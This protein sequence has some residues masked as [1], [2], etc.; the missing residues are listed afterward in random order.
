MLKKVTGRAA[1]KEIF[2][3]TAEEEPTVQGITTAEGLG[4]M[5]FGGEVQI[6]ISWHW[7]IG[8]CA[9]L[10]GKHARAQ[11]QMVTFSKECGFQEQLHYRRG[12]GRANTNVL[13]TEYSSKAAICPRAKPVA[14]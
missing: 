1:R 3:S 4:L 12:R 9:A 6:N 10:D 11:L 7:W 13:T 8:S 2:K 5:L 14:I